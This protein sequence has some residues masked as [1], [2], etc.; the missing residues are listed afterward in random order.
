[1]FAEA[2][3]EAGVEKFVLLSALGAD[4]RSSIFY[5][6]VKGE[7][8]D[9]VTNLNFKSLTILRP[10][11]LEGPRAEIRPGEQLARKIMNILNPLMIGGLRKYR[12][13]DIDKVTSTMA[14]AAILE[15]PGVRIIGNEEILSCI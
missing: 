5:N 8:E 14:E 11:L 2:C 1:M 13:V 15:A 12:S 7:L 9:A 6:R 3:K 4:S 10:S